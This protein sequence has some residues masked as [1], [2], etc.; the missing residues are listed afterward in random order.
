MG[1]VSSSWTI[2]TICW[3]GMR[4]SKTSEPTARSVTVF[5][6][7]RTTLKLTSAS[8]RASFISR[9]PSL[10]SASVSLPLLRNFLKAAFILSTKLSNTANLRKFFY[11]ICIITADNLSRRVP[12]QYSAG[13]CGPA[14]C[15]SCPAVY[16]LPQSGGKS[17]YRM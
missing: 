10:T 4:L 16:L 14:E 8:S 2:L 11:N 12:Q 17:S 9:M 7:S 5:I 15:E 1:F 13:N 3:P 6:K